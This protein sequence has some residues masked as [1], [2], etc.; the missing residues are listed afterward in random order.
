MTQPEIYINKYARDKLS[1]NDIFN[2]F[3]SLEVVDQKE[4][5]NKLIYFLYQ[6]HPSEDIITKAIK[7]TPIKQ[8]MT[9][10]VLFKTKAFN[11]AI[12]KTQQLPDSELKKAFIFMLHLFKLADTYRR[13]TQCKNG[14][15]HEWHH[16]N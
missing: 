12:Q 10:C 4:V 7:T 13:N 3:Q 9:P 11:I 14:C 1:Y 5:R 15:T 6:N 16:L 8:T 2:W